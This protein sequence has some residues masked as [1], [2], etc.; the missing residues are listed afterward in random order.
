MKPTSPPSSIPHRWRSS[1]G[2]LV[3][4]RWDT[5]ALLV[6]VTAYIVTVDGL[7]SALRRTAIRRQRSTPRHLTAV[8]WTPQPVFACPVVLSDPG[9]LL[10]RSFLTAM[11]PSSSASSGSATVSHAQGI[12]PTKREMRTGATSSLRVVRAHTVGHRDVRRRK[13]S[14]RQE[15]QAPPPRHQTWS[16]LCHLPSRR[17]RVANLPIA[18][19]TS[20][21]KPMISKTKRPM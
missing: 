12:R 17:L 7:Q 5:F 18:I 4:P 2:R 11:P 19:V 3:W 21:R 1:A 14:C 20:P 15:S 13:Q 16:P 8:A 10:E 9:Q 6:A